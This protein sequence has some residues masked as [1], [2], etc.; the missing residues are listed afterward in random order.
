[1]RNTRA[2]IG[3][4]P[5]V[6]A[7]LAVCA[8]L[9]IAQDDTVRGTLTLADRGALLI[10]DQVL[11]D[12]VPIRVLRFGQ[13]GIDTVAAIPGAP[14]LLEP[15]EK[16]AIIQRG[17]FVG[18]ADLGVFAE[19]HPRWSGAF[20]IPEGYVTRLEGAPG[21]AGPAI[22]VQPVFTPDGKMRYNRDTKQFQ[23][24]LRIVLRDASGVLEPR[25]LDDPILMEIV[26]N[27]DA[28]R[29][30]T[31]SISRTYLPATRVRLV[32]D[33]PKDS[34]RINFI[35]PAKPEG[36]EV[37]LAVEPALIVE[38]NRDRM[39]GWGI[40]SIP[41]TVVVRGATLPDS[42]EVH[43]QASLGSLDPDVVVVRSGRP[44][45]TR[46]RSESMGAATVTAISS[47]FAPIEAD[48]EYTPPV[49]FLVSSVVGGLA[50][51]AGAHLR[52]RKQ[53]KK[54]GVGATLGFGV[55]WGLIA[56]LL[57]GILGVNLIGID[58]PVVEHFNEG[59]VF[60]LSAAAAIAAQGGMSTKSVAGPAG[61]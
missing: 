56:A 60:V 15:D 1:M 46:L 4:A 32:D 43:M 34:V 61:A 42:I 3:L 30:P 39:Q 40:Q 50:G 16:L 6:V 17:D 41:I 35:T 37:H 59:L 47:D 49:P 57:Y 52:R 33:S 25:D 22:E 27:A 21:A 48:L 12:Q 45:T 5:V 36:Y 58:V 18:R 19:R 26:S 38:A 23:G 14:V 9:S 20:A 11:F 29:P 44:A 28:V 13:S 10:R 2:L 51:G 54:S 53:G 31:V 24:S 7:A 55:L 8:V